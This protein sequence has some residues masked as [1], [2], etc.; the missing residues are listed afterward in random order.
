LEDDALEILILWQL[1]KILYTY[2]WFT[3]VCSKTKSVGG[4]MIIDDDMK[5]TD[6][7]T[8]TDSWL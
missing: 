7:C 5:R 8:I 2:K 1:D 3:A 6:N 4:P